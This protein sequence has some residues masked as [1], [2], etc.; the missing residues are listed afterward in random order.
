L[1]PEATAAAAAGEPPFDP[2]A[3]EVRRDPYPHYRRLRDEQPVA[4]LAGL[5]WYA[6]TRHADVERILRSPAQFSSSI[7]K[8]ADRTLLGQDPPAHTPARR[9]AARAFDKRRMQALEGWIAATAR[10]LVRRFVR[11]GGGDFV[12]DLAVEL[13][14]RTIAHLL[15]IG[16]DRLDEFKGW[17]EAVVMGASRLIPPGW[18]A[19]HAR[20]IEGFDR[21]FGELVE[22]RRRQ[23]GDDVVSALCGTADVAS[24]GALATDEAQSLAKLLLIAGNETTTNLMANAMRILLVTP[25]LERRLRDDPRLCGAWVEE[26]LRYDSPVQIVLRRATADAEIEGTRIPRGAAVAAFLGAANRDERHHPD[27]EIFR[28]GRTEAHLAFGTGPHHCLGATLARLEATLGLS[29]LLAETR[30]LE[31]AEDLAAIPPIPALQLRGLQRLRLAA[32]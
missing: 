17:S 18:E 15:G 29:M 9:S 7:M 31:A 25:G 30:H 32:A 19:E 10:T 8:G 24:P 21:F 5:K 13:P 11:S 3:L 14:I 22:R 23:P 28:L 27:P 26:T 12:R 20:Q 16:D 4:F 1:R 6:V 2:R